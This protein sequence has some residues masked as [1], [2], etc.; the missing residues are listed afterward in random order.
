LPD[1]APVS[2]SGLAVPIVGIASGEGV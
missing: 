1:I 2:K